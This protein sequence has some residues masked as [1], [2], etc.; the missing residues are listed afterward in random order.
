M[1]ER[2]N[3][4]KKNL[5]RFPR[6]LLTAKANQL[7]LEYVQ[8]CLLNGEPA[9]AVQIN[10]HWHRRFESEYGLSLRL[11]NRKYAVPRPIVKERMEIN[12]VN[13]FRLRYLIVLVFGYDP[14]LLNFDQSPFHHNETGSQNKPTL[15]IKGST[16]PVVEGNSD[17]KSRWT[18]NLTAQSEFRDYDPENQLSRFPFPSAECMFKAEDGGPVN[19]RL[20]AFRA[21]HNFP[22][23]FTVTVGP[24]GSYREADVIEWLKRHLEPWRPG[25]DWRIY[26]CDDYKCHKTELVRKYCWQCGYVRVV[27]GG[28]TTPY[29]QPP[30]TDLNEFV[31]ARYGHKESE[32]LLDKMRG[33]QVVPSLSHEECMMVMFEVLSDPALH[34]HAAKGFKYVGHAVELHGKEDQI[35]CREAGVLWN[36]TTTDGYPNMRAKINAE[37]QELKEEFDSGGLT[38]CEADVLRLITKYPV[39]DKIDRV[40]ENLGEDFRHDS[41]H[42]LDNDDLPAVAAGQNEAEL[43]AV[44]AGDADAQ[45]GDDDTTS[46]GADSNDER[47]DFSTIAVASDDLPAVAATESTAPCE[48]L[49]PVRGD[50]NVEL[51]M[52]TIH[53]L[54]GHL[55]GLRAIGCTRGVQ[56]LEAELQK[57]NRKLRNMTE[58]NA[59]VLNTFN[60]L[61]RAEELRRLEQERATAERKDRWRDAQR[62]IAVEKEA[63]KQLQVKRQKLQELESVYACKHAIKNFPLDEL[64]KGSPNAGGVKGRRNRWEVLDRLARL[65]AGLSPGQRNDWQWFKEAWDKAMVTQHGADWPEMFATW[66]QEVLTDKRSNALSTF[67]YNETCRVFQGTAALQVPGG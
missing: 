62:A 27:H 67:V 36:E 51:V 23:W 33:G 39:H 31:R 19:K 53:E 7:Q 48:D 59:S 54:Q 65:Q 14:I 29:G 56:C 42:R 38:W 8:A 46:N 30:D 37:L 17:V 47:E 66:M 21:E 2:R 57:A 4:G 35:I 22:P 41:L 11:A 18:A 50:A 3:R 28:G 25:R 40:L 61:R 5:C 58:A 13:I 45:A 44:A 16:V 43:S 26:L 52:D 10:G 6:S 9:V 34:I 1:A 20:Q 32:L 49:V 60:S 15:A 24:K 63:T 55:E 12:W 64:G